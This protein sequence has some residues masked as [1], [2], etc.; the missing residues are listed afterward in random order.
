METYTHP[1]YSEYFLTSRPPTAVASKMNA[2]KTKGVI[3]K[4]TQIKT[5]DVS[6]PLP[7]KADLRSVL[8]RVR[9][10]RAKL[11]YP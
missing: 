2:L 5:K 1:Q 11:S 7:R 8:C 9:L 10:G 3:S 4:K 6:I